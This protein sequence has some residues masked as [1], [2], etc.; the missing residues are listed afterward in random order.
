MRPDAAHLDQSRPKL[1]KQLIQKWLL[2]KC[3]AIFLTTVFGMEVVERMTT[4]IIGDVRV[5]EL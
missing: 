3:L 1:Q 5:D 4:Q 2:K